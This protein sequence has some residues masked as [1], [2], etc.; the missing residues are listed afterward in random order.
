MDFTDV[1]DTA[2]RFAG[3]KEDGNNYD[4]LLVDRCHNRYTVAL[5]ICFCIAMSTY[6]YMG[7]TKESN[8]NRE[9]EKK[10]FVIT[11]N[12]L[13]CWVPAQFTG[14][15]EDYTNRLCYIQNTYHV[16]KNQVVPQNFELR[17]ERTIKYYQWIHFVLLLQAFFFSLPRIIWQLFNDKIG[18]SIGNLVYASNQYQAFDD[19]ADRNKGIIFNY[20]KN[21]LYDLI[22]Y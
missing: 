12:P 11:G 18:L 15:Y 9:R 10:N 16:P 13:E 17:R 21:K 4:D 8:D 3:K 22:F 5:L 1:I 20:N 14:N 7:K 19:D 2:K 6:Q